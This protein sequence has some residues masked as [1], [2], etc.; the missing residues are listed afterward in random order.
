[1]GLRSQTLKLHGPMRPYA[2]KASVLQIRSAKR[3]FS[4]K[5]AQAVSLA[6]PGQPLLVVS[7]N[8]LDC[9]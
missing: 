9:S 4:R 2:S 3:L 7:R 6:R 1:M 8:G 5:A